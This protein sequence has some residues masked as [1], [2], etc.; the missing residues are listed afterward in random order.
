LQVDQLAS[1]IAEVSKRAS[2]DAIVDVGAGQGHLSRV[3]AFRYGLRTIS[4]EA[5]ASLTAAASERAQKLCRMKRC[6]TCGPMQLPL[7]VTAAAWTPQE[8]LFAVNQ[9]LGAATRHRILFACLHACGDLTPNVLRTFVECGDAVAVVAVGCCYNLVSEAGN[10]EGGE[11]A[12]ASRILAHTAHAGGELAVAQPERAPVQAS[13]ASLPGYPMSAPLAHHTLGRQARML[14]CQ[15]AERWRDAEE[16]RSWRGL[17]F[18]ASLEVVL[19]SCPGVDASALRG[20]GAACDAATSFNSYIHESFARVGVECPLGDHELE[21]L[22]R[23]ELEEPAAYMGPFCTLRC[24]LAAPTEALLV[25]D[26]V[27]YLREQIEED[28]SV[29]WK[30]VFDAHISPR[31]VAIVALTSALN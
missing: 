25:L 15:S 8:L 16:T 21:A 5:V 24:V 12:A 9:A 11:R 19:L 26:R 17:A 2:A 30:N 1:L 3:L 23:D 22:W 28:H 20:G 10:P 27:L 18:R 4:V 7:C 6:S 14:A 31:N 13:D 29:F